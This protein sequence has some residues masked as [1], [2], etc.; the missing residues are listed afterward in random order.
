MQKRYSIFGLNNFKFI[1]IY[2][3]KTTSLKKNT[4][5][6]LLSGALLLKT[7]WLSCFYFF[8]TTTYA[9]SK[10]IENKKQ[11]IFTEQLNNVLRFSPSA[12]YDMLIDKKGYLFMATSNGLYRYDGF[13]LDHWALQTTTGQSISS[14]QEDEQGRI[15]FRDFNSTLYFFDGQQIQT[16]IASAQKHKQHGEIFDFIIIKKN[17]YVLHLEAIIKYNEKGKAQI[18]DVIH[19]PNNSFYSIVPYNGGLA[20]VNKNAELFFYDNSG[21][22]KK[23]DSFV[24][25]NGHFGLRFF[26]K[27]LFLTL[28][29]QPNTP[30]YD[31]S[32]KRVISLKA[33]TGLAVNHATQD[34]NFFWLCTSKGAYPF[35]GQSI[36]NENVL[37]PNKA[38][39]DVVRDRWG[40]LWISTLDGLLYRAEENKVTQHFPDIDANALLWQGKKLL[41]A[42]NDGYLATTQW[43]FGN[44]TQSKQNCGFEITFLT[45][46]KPQEVLSNWGIWNYA[47]LT[48]NP[49]KLGRMISEDTNGDLLMAHY[50][51]AIVA[52][53]YFL[54]KPKA[55][56]SSK[57]LK[58][59]DE[60]YQYL[61]R[62]GR[63]ISCA[64]ISGEFRYAVGFSDGLF[65]FDTQGNK[66]QEIKTPEG[67]EIRATALLP[68]QDTLWIA[69]QKGL[70]YVEL[71]NAK[72]AR[73][74]SGGFSAVQ[75]QRGA[76]N[77]LF[78]IDSE[79]HV[80]SYRTGE[81]LQ[82]HF[83]PEDPILLKVR[84]L[85]YKN[86]TVILSTS[87]G[88]LVLKTNYNTP[89][90][91]PYLEIDTLLARQKLRQKQE[92]IVGTALAF[93]PRQIALAAKAKAKIEYCTDQDST[94]REWDT[95][96][97]GWTTETPTSGVHWLSFRSKGLWGTSV[98]LKV[99]WT[100]VNPPFT[101][102]LPWV[103][104]ILAV[105]GIGGGIGYVVFKRRQR[106][107][108][109]TAAMIE[110]Q[111]TA[112]GAQMNPHFIFNILQSVQGLVFEDDK[113]KVLSLLSEYAELTRRI[114]DFSDKKWISIGD[115]IKTLRLYLKLESGRFSEGDELNWHIEKSSELSNEVLIPSQI[116]Q[117]LAE[118]AVKHGLL[119]VM[120]KKE[121]K[122]SIE[123]ID[124]NHVKIS[125]EDNGIG[126]KQSTKKRSSLHK[127]FATNAL[128]KRIALFS[129]M[130][131]SNI[132]LE[133]IDKEADD[134]A[135]GT[136][137]IIILPIK[138]SNES[139][140]N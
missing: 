90:L 44:Y 137:V 129:Q 89:V 139:L 83:L 70:Y 81:Q 72:K 60:Y 39:S 66:E 52:G 82:C 27:K 96:K 46:H 11:T 103:L 134:V 26:K 69:S 121:L 124:A 51:K 127:P 47:K 95:R 57:V 126:R 74:A 63:A 19:T 101:L 109:L 20:Y 122:I 119:H 13:V 56:N 43:P 132:Q 24:S 54:E 87:K 106:M 125:V 6:R 37:L 14:L 9:S 111:L 120:G 116:I 61:L 113:N 118:N 68:Y 115:E 7:V 80:L 94:W 18:I 84:N 45:N 76:G 138:T 34:D 71:R 64:I 22:I 15:W 128:Q 40:G 78:L 97:Y 133:Y 35:D 100:V 93:A 75:M 12:I 88:I 41:I 10:T 59:K 17:I 32:E 117:P 48:L 135:I 1:C 21:K 130:T 2:F 102:T 53:N 16:H 123:K 8:L 112:L 105:L 92:I 30:L 107:Q 85:Q 55:P 110:S 36:D 136:E 49:R 31:L 98:P 50:T 23:Q 114:L 86:D 28:R 58:P 5:W 104:S 77:R 73:L 42:T 79:N 33:S 29:G 25:E 131:R 62:N 3:Y 99:T 140:T 91:L 67:K 108:A 65:L 4:S 38:V